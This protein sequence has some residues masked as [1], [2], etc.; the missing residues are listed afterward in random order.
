MKNPEAYRSWLTNN[1]L[2]DSRDNRKK[3]RKVNALL[4]QYN[5]QIG[6]AEYF[7]KIQ[8]SRWGVNSLDRPTA[9][10]EKWLSRVRATE[11]AIKEMR[12]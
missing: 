3:H 5:H 4:R 2:H 11:L 9:D 12:K 10:L 6:M 7:R 8:V 1:R